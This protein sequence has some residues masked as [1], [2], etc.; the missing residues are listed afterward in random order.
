MDP[1]AIAFDTWLIREGPDRLPGSRSATLMVM[2]LDGSQAPPSIQVEHPP[3][4][5]VL[6]LTGRIQRRAGCVC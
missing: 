5:W 4:D 1:T 6:I 2:I 3:A